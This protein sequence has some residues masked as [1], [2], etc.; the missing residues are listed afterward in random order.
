M[1]FYIMNKYGR[2]VKSVKEG[3]MLTVHDIDNALSFPS[4]SAA[5][6]YITENISRPSWVHVTDCLGNIL[7]ICDNYHFCHHT[8]KCDPVR[9]VV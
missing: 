7:T 9:L 3:A 4:K 6:K 1:K 2:Y 8:P 5:D